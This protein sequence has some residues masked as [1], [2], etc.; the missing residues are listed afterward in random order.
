MVVAVDED[1]A[2]T[3]SATRVKGTATYVS[4]LA[5]RDSVVNPTGSE[6]TLWA[7]AKLERLSNKTAQKRGLN[8]CIEL[9]LSNGWM[10]G[11]R[12]LVGKQN[13]RVFSL[14]LEAI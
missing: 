2:P 3:N 14:R 11:S 13:P 12:F 8:L 4:E 1:I 5:K 9:G 10:L 7:P 6:V